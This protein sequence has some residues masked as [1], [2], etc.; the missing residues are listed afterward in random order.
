M[1]VEISFHEIWSSE[2]GEHFHYEYFIGKLIDFGVEN[3]H[4]GTRL[5]YPVSVLRLQKQF[6][7]ASKSTYWF[8]TS[9]LRRRGAKTYQNR[10]NCN[11]EMSRKLYSRAI[12]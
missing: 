11:F 3:V 10:F 6:L 12:F 8:E 2:L 9:H 4:L 7:Q 5:G 1:C